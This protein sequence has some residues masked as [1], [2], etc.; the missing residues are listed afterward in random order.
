MLS[1]RQNAHADALPDFRNLG[2]VAR[3]LVAVN[4]LVAAAALADETAWA[5][6]LEVI[7]RNAAQV[8]PPLIARLAVL[9]VAAGEHLIEEP[10]VA[11]E[12]EFGERFV[13]VHRNGLV[14]RAA[15]RGFERSKGN[16]AGGAAAADEEPHWSVVV[17]GV[18][19]RLPVGRRQWSA[20]K[21]A[22]PEAKA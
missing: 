2:V 20:V 1:I 11:I 15:I 10:L 5:A 19:E 17:E 4:L 13:R 14:A 8:E 9:Y 18:A 3:V 16:A 12:R 7:A 21:G 6:I 22:L